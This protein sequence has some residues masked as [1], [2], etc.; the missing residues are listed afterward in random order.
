MR[1]GPHTFYRPKAVLDCSQNFV[2]MTSGYMAVLFIS[3]IPMTFL[4]PTHD[5]GN[6]LFAN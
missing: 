6:P 5:N 4:K 2:K 1:K 3:I